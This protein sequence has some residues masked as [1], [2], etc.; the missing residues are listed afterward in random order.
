TITDRR[1]TTST[2]TPSALTQVPLRKPPGA[3]PHRAASDSVAAPI[4]AASGTTASPAAM[5][6]ASEGASSQASA[7]D[8]GMAARSQR[9]H[10][11]QNATDSRT[12]VT[13]PSI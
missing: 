8:T 10:G 4:S 9:A 11:I 13:G 3:G 5:N 1:A 7:Q 6:T 2:S 12:A